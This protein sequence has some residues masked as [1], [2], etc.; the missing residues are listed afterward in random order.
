MISKRGRGVKPHRYCGPMFTSTT[1]PLRGTADNPGLLDQ[2]HAGKIV[3]PQFQRPWVWTHNRTLALVKSIAQTWPAGGLLL[4]EGDRGFPSRTLDFVENHPNEPIYSVLDGQQRLTALYLAL[5]GLAPRHM[6]YVRLGNIVKRGSPLDEDFDVMTKRAWGLAYSSPA[7]AVS[8]RVIPVHEIASEGAWFAWL[9]HLP[10]DERDAYLDVRETQLG[11]LRS[12]QFPVSVVSKNAPLEILTNVFVTINQQ[13]VRLGAFDLMVAKS[14]LDPAEHPPGYDLRQIW[15]SAIGSE[16]SPASHQRLANFRIDGIVALRL[17]KL[18]VS[19]QGSVGNAEIL[20]LD[21][22]AVRSNFA[23]ALNALEKTLE[24]LEIDAALVSESLPPEAGLIPLAYVLARDPQV[25]S[26]PERRAQ[27]IQWFWASTFLQRYGKGGTNT[28]VGPDALAAFDW[29]SGSEDPPKWIREFWETFQ[30]TDLL[31]TQQTNESLLR[32]IY[33]LQSHSGARDWRTGDAIRTLGRA[34]VSGSAKPVSRLEGH[35]IFPSD[36]ALP[37]TGGELAAGVEI[38]ADHDLV[39]N[40][41]L[42]L[43]STN[44]D[45]QATPP[46]ALTGRDIDLEL[47]KSHLIDPDSLDN[48]DDFVRS[49]VRQITEHLEKILPKP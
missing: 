10:K 32:G 35:H 15:Q 45:L 27:V 16:G 23:A 22:A 37:G 12:Y 17:V 42:L 6:L 20:A 30:E 28:I 29:I 36:N 43:G 19:P 49:R 41:A 2:V 31:E 39:I 44:S 47:V 8:D 40:R 34:P 7:Q 26:D 1:L 3:V 18:L 9:E 21:G 25:A 4:M 5:W 11:G 24:V 13:G 46:D 14:W 48:W 38:P 33:T